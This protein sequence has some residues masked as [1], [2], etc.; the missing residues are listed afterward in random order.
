MEARVG[1]L[2]VGTRFI[3][4]LTGREGEVRDQREGET[5]VQFGNCAWDQLHVGLHPHVR[6]RV[7]ER[8]H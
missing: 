1:T 7:V 8:V 6:V 5:V 2:A 4:L 3:T